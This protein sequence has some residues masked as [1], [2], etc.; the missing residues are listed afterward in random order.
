M[1]NKRRLLLCLAMGGCGPEPQGPPVV[2]DAP[3]VVMTTTADDYSA[4]AMA[5]W[6]RAGGVVAD[7]AAV[8]GDAVVKVIGDDVW[9]IQRLG[10]DTLRRYDPLVWGRPQVEVSVGQGSNPQD[11]AQ[12]GGALWVPRYERDSL[13]RLD[14]ATGETLGEVSLAAY[15]DTDGL[16]EMSQ[17][18]VRGNVAWIVLQR[19]RR[20]EAWE[21]DPEG[22]VVGFDC[23]SLQEVAYLP[24]GPNPRAVDAGVA[25]EFVLLSEGRLERLQ[26]ST[27]VVQPWM[28][29]PDEGPF[30]LAALEGDRGVV[31]AWGDTAHHVGCIDGDRLTWA[32]SSP[33]YLADVEL[34]SAE[35]AVV[36]ARRGWTDPE[37][38][39]GVDRVDLAACTRVGERERGTL[40][41]YDLA[42][43]PQRPP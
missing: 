20:D 34:L 10:V 28:D 2:S 14:P 8:H 21:A 36:A 22:A 29:V 1:V 12:C 23:T 5:Q 3:D 37:L 18:L 42:V 38:A 33:S 26:L 24:V 15:A 35:E 9:V 40:A 11:V 39:G 25:D 31:L 13:L 41:P 19:L 4:G 6:S 27:G 17:V 30:E 16:P 32:Y 43:W 7:R